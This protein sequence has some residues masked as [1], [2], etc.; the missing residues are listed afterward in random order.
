M[1][2]VLSYELQAICRNSGSHIHVP[3]YIPPCLLCVAYSCKTRL[4]LDESSHPF[5]TLILQLSKLWFSDLIWSLT[6]YRSWISCKHKTH[7]QL[8][9]Y[10]Y[11]S[12]LHSFARQKNRIYVHNEVPSPSPSELC[13]HC[14]EQTI[15]HLCMKSWFELLRRTDEDEGWKAQHANANSGD[16]FRFITASGLKPD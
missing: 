14:P 3:M 16:T 11:L 2:W 6:G 1:R 12:L 4:M 13:S 7:W 5:S 9:P 8:Q 10:T 15:L